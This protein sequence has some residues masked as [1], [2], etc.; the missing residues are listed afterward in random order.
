M[1]QDR[2]YQD[3]AEGSE[4]GARTSLSPLVVHDELAGSFPLM[5]GESQWL[6]TL[7]ADELARILADD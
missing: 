3:G 6:M 5:Q 7:L 4:D 1:A 2:H